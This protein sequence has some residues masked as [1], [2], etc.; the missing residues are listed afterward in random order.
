MNYRY[1]AMTQDGQKLQGIIDAN[2]ER[3]ARLRLRE[4]GL[5][6]LDIRPQ[7]S[8]GVKT[9]RPRISHSE[10]TLFTRQLATLSAAAL[11]LEES[12][13]V[14]GQQ[15]SNKR[16]G[17]VLNQVRSAI[18]EGHPLSDA[19][20]HFPTLFDSLYRTLVKAG[21]KS[22]LLGTLMVRAAD[23]QETLQQNRIALTLSIFEPALII[24]MALIVLFIVVSVL[25]PLLQL[26]SMIN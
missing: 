13:A 23:N 16:L 11:P 18:L 8:S 26:N 12:L 2:D 17:D 6:L 3:Q 15:S 10:L 25:Q 4:E 22:G 7:K 24:T 19:L 21:E 20:Q 14:I 9:R 5:F 1:R